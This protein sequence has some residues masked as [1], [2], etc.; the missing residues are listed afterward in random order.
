MT[1]IS[2]SGIHNYSNYAY[3]ILKI[4]QLYAELQQKI[5]PEDRTEWKYAE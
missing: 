1:R 5:M 3:L 2:I 4:L